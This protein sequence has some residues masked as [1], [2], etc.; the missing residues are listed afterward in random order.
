MRFPNDI[1]SENSIEIIEQNFIKEYEFR[2]G[3]SIQDIC[4]EVVTW[5][6]IVSGKFSEIIPNQII[7]TEGKNALKDIKSAFLMGD[8]SYSDVPVYNRYD[9]KPNETFDGPAVI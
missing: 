5:R 1:W 9:L 2:Y 4:I 7:K 6:V 8:K 3:R